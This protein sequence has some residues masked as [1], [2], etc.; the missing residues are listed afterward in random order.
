M[1][2]QY[3]YKAVDI[4]KKKFTGV[5]LAEDEA[6]L[7]SQLEKQGLY[8]VSSK[9]YSGKTPSAFFTLGTGKI[10]HTEIT[11]FCRNFSVMINSGLSVI[12]CLECLK[13]Q[14]FSMYFKG[15]LQI[16]YDD[17]KGGDMMSTAL[18]KH[19]KAFPE[20]FRNMVKV[21]ERS[22][23]LAEVFNQLAVYYEKDHSVKSKTKVALSYPMIL[24][25][26]TFGII[27]LMTLYVVPTFKSSL[28]A[29]EVEI[30][31]ITKIAYDI[32]DFIS[33]NILEIL[34]A[35]ILVVLAFIGFGKT[36]IGRQC[37]DWLK[38]HLPLIKKININLVSARFSRCFS[39][40][41]SSGMDLTEA[42]DS[43]VIVFGNVDVEKR[44]KLA[45]EQIKNGSSVA[46]AF[47][48]YKLFP[49]ILLQM[50]GVAERTASFEFVLERAALFF[51]DM[52]DSAINSF[53]NKL[54]PIILCFLG[55]VVGGLFIAV[56][57]PIL[58]MM[59]G[60]NPGGYNI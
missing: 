45:V 14:A 10:K 40:L 26:L 16:V 7:A 42:L 30:T 49:P 35:I 25:V 47:E 44:F 11:N 12:D 34:L 52:V 38:L 6:D 18:E 29:L 57:S 5:F 24:L 32:S 13:N 58:S 51:D 41:I 2:K 15:I 19:K 22:C 9:P 50:I 43:V 17:V 20:F 4:N 8:L 28:N 60:L 55:L 3:K 36:K 54:Q 27:A 46:K 33:A 21:G 37:Y 56:Y 1:Q 53:V 39:L 59:D 31:G 48:N 23:K